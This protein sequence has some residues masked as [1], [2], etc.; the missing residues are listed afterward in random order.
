[1][2][3]KLRRVSSFGCILFSGGEL[4]VK[5]VETRINC[6]RLCFGIF[7]TKILCKVACIIKI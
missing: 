5:E 6:K 7:R 4:S 1:M 3:L 2:V